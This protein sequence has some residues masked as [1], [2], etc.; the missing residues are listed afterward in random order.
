MPTGYSGSRCAGLCSAGKGVLSV[1]AA[2]SPDQVTWYW[3]P[4]TSPR[5]RQAGTGLVLSPSRA[6]PPR[7]QSGRGPVSWGLCGLS[8]GKPCVQDPAV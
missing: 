8:G 5:R 4:T 6:A 3:I 7:W 1:P 2:T